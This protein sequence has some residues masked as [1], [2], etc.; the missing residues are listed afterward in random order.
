M[1]SGCLFGVHRPPFFG[2]PVDQGHLVLTD[3]N[4]VP[5]SSNREPNK[6]EDDELILPDLTAQW[7]VN[8]ACDVLFEPRF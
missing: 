7:R 4:N 8:P 3:D 5:P 1:A 6:A 2:R